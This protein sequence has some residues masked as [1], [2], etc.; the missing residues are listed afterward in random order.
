MRWLEKI[1]FRKHGV[2]GVEV[3][4][5]DGTIVSGIRFVQLF[6]L[7]DPHRFVSVIREKRGE[8]E[9]KE[10]GVLEALDDLPRGQQALVREALKR[11]FFLPEI[12]AIRKVVTAG[13]IDEWIV[14]T[15]R[16]D[17]TIVVCDRKQSIHFCHDGMLLITDM[18]KC[19]YRITRPEE[20]DPNSK[21]L[22][23]Q[24]MP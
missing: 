20:L 8:S 9:E 3:V 1:T 15:D 2:D 5:P 14:S 24:A 10:L 22:L 17:K 12:T 21:H 13:G 4:M 23:E 16:G 19:R 6:P 7:R 18:D 11:S